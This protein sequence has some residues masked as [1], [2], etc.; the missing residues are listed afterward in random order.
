MLPSMGNTIEV[1]RADWIDL[2]M[3]AKRRIT[4]HKRS[5]QREADLKEQLRQKK[6]QVSS[7]TAEIERKDKH[8]QQLAAQNQWLKKQVFGRSTEQR[9]S[10]DREKTEQTEQNP[11]KPKEPREEGNKKRNRGQQPGTEGHGRRRRTELPAKETI[12][13][14]PP[15]QRRCPICG[16]PYGDRG[17]TRDSEQVEYVVKIYRRVHKRKCYFAT[18]ECDHRAASVTAPVP[19]KVIPKGMVHRSLITHVLMEKWLHQRPLGRVLEALR[20]EGL[21]LAQGTITGALRRITEMLRPVYGRLLG[22]SR[23]ADR[24]KMDETGWMVFLPVEDEQSSRRWWLWV[25]ITEETVVFLL[26]P[27]RSGQV[28]KKHL[29]ADAAGVLLVDRYGGYKVLPEGIVL[30]YCWAHVRRDFVRVAE[31]DSYQSL[32]RW[33]ERWIDRIAEL[34]RLNKQ[35]LAAG[36]DQQAFAHWDRLLREQIEQM[37]RI[38]QQQLKRPNLSRKARA[39]LESLAEHWEGCTVFADHPEVPMDNNESERRLRNP[40]CGRKNY[41]GCGSQ[42]STELT[43]MLFSVFSTLKKNDINPKEWLDAYLEACAEAG[44]EA[45]EEQTLESFLPWNLPEERKK[46]W[47]L[48]DRPP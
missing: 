2:R 14:L 32:H 31:S 30:A 44:G 24:W 45:P 6:Q 4:L 15:D 27:T 46:E 43:A 10:K 3:E 13:A 34:Y 48:S 35:R 28:P 37:E 18:C 21:E 16:L 23:S 19:P 20:V 7:L 17:L 12:H 25:V 42:W 36:E 41:Y 33:A 29:G 22:R 39:V 26:E 40:A 5:M 9:K 1:Q 47:E 11:P 38:R 8:I